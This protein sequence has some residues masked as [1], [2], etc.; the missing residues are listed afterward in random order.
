MKETIEKKGNEFFVNVGVI[1]FEVENQ[2]VAYAPA[3][4]ISSYGESKEDARESLWKAIKTF[5]D[6]IA[7]KNTLTED[8]LNL[9]WAVKKKPNLLFTAP[10]FD[11]ETIVK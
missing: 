1:A 11:I 4:E 9:G 8:L 10:T 6:D 2:W 7:D 3:L 5:I